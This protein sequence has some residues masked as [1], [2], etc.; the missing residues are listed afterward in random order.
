MAMNITELHAENFE[1]E[2]VNAD[3]PFQVRAAQ[4][5]TGGIYDGEHCGPGGDGLPDALAGH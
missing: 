2:V 3:P 4:S 1:Q 5:H